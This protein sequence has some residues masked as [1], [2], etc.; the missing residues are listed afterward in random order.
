MRLIPLGL[1]HACSDKPPIKILATTLD[2]SW[3]RS[4]TY[5]KERLAVKSVS[6]CQHRKSNDTRGNRSSVL[7]SYSLH[8]HKL[9]QRSLTVY[10]AYAESLFTLPRTVAVWSTA[11]IVA[12]SR[13]SVCLSAPRIICHKPH[14]QIPRNFMYFCLRQWLGPP[15][16]TVHNV[17]MYFRF[18][19]LPPYLSPLAAANVLVRHWRCIGIAHCSSCQRWT[20]AFKGWQVGDKLT[21]KHPSLYA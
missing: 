3:I 19:G 21:S 14:V 2:R 7:W 10:W 9:V 17:M 1:Y 13:L 18:C 20:S 8:G 11:I 12:W 6:F 16:T 5:Y 15:M 4:I